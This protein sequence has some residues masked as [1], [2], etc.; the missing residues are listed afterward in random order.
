LAAWPDIGWLATGLEAAG[1]GTT[2]VFNLRQNVAVLIPKW[3]QNI[4]ETAGVS[5]MS[6]PS[7]YD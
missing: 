4:V 7:N 2:I 3:N 5:E 1:L 6:N